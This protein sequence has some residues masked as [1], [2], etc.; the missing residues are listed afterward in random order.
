[1]TKRCCHCREEKSLDS[2]GQDKSRSDGLNAEC[3]VCMKARHAVYYQKNKDKVTR[4]DLA[5]YQSHKRECKRSARKSSLR[6]RFGITEGDYIRI[7]TRQLG[8]CAICGQPEPKGQ[9]LSV[10]HNHVTGQVRGLLCDACNTAMGLL[11]ED[12]QRLI[13]MLRYLEVNP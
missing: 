1:M 2:F 12:S 4:R 8:R 9:W 5:Y 11:K 7:F 6:R 3:K 10:D 13:S